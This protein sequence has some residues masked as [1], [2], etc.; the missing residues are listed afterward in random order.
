MTNDRIRV[1]KCVI[2][3]IESNLVAIS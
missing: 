1:L 2:D 3:F